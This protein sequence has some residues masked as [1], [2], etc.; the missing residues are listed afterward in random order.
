MKLT[1]ILPGDY[2]EELCEHRQRYLSTLLSPG[3]EVKIVTTGGTPSLT[4]IVDLALI[5]PGMVNR[6]MEAEKGGFDGVLIH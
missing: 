6:T 4:S 5:A 2:G 3:A 1:V